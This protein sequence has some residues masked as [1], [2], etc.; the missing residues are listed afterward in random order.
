MLQLILI[1]EMREKREREKNTERDNETS[2]RRVLR[3]DE[4]RKKR[5]RASDR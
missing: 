4:A 5:S 2:Q 3:H 1:N